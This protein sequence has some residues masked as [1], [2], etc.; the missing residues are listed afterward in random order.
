MGLLP[1]AQSRL[2]ETGHGL[3]RYLPISDSEVHRTNGSFRHAEERIGRVLTQLYFQSGAL[4]GDRE[5]NQKM[6]RP[7]SA[8]ALILLF[9]EVGR[10]A[11]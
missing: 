1:A 6:G 11:I 8:W 5:A 4:L 2:L 9:L 3:N 7:R 10:L